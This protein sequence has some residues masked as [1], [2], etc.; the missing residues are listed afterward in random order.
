VEPALSAI[1]LVFAHVVLAVQAGFAYLGR[2]RVERPP[3][4][5]LN[6]RDVAFAAVVLVVVPPLYLRIPRLL[7]GA[8]LV[9]VGVGVL[10]F[11]LGPLLGRLWGLAA[12]AALVAVDVALALGAGGHSAA[13][14][15]VNNLLVVALTVGVCNLWVQ[16]GI[17]AR[18]VAVFAAVLT[19]YDVLATLAF[20]VMLEFSARVATLPLAPALGWGQ[21]R[22]T[23]AVGLGDLLLVLLWALVCEVAFG[24]R[25]ALV[26]AGLGLAAVLGLFA[27]FWLDLVNR[28]VPAMVAL[29]P[30]IVLHRAVL[31]RRAGPE[32]RIGRYLAARDGRPLPAGAPAR[33]A[34]T[35]TAGVARLPAPGQ[36]APADPGRYLALQGDEVVASG[37]TVGE[38]VRAAGRARPGVVP[39]IVLDGLPQ[40][41]EPDD[42]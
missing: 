20:P 25:A 37:W 24:R 35:L 8:I 33:E 30:L 27:A 4:G 40:P 31:A 11:T 32:R 2:F 18:D 41:A 21:G 3:V 16:S 19:V 12:A 42:R 26:G 5:V 13:F 39:L 36:P 1:L 34:A 9:V 17:R 14:L 22:G 6:L 38:A 7:V 28:P 29:G 10:S 15:V 23:V